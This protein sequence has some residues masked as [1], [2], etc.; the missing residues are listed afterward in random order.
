MPGFHSRGSGTHLF[1]AKTGSLDI[2]LSAKPKDEDTEME[3]RLKV[4]IEYG[5]N[6]EDAHQFSEL[7]GSGKPNFPSNPISN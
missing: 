2:V 4:T 5:E 6:E 3:V 7:C 1:I